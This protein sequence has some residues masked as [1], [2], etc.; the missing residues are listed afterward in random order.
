MRYLVEALGIVP[1]PL[2]HAQTA[3]SSFYDHEWVVGPFRVLISLLL[4][5]LVIV[6]V[7]VVIRKLRPDEQ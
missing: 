3:S 1:A 5:G 7:I 6:G 2:A 4:V